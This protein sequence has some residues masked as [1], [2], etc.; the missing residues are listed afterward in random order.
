MGLRPN[1]VVETRKVPIFTAEILSQRQPLGK[2][3]SLRS[4]ITRPRI[5]RPHNKRPHIT[6]PCI[7]RPRILIGPVL[8]TRLLQTSCLMLKLQSPPP[9]PRTSHP[10][11][12]LLSRSGYP[13]SVSSKVASCQ[14]KVEG[15]RVWRSEHWSWTGWSTCCNTIEA[16][17]SGEEHWSVN[18]RRWE[19]S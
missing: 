16:A 8:F 12:L 2:W 11:N 9:S 17:M 3:R 1:L 19:R 5:T 13:Y 15:Y 18:M 14:L 7:I 6:H 4:H 10:A